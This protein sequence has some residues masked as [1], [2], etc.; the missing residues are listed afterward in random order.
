M[1][2]KVEGQRTRPPPA[3]LALGEEEMVGPH[4]TDNACHVILH[5]VDPRFLSEMESHDVASF[6][7]QAL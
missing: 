5:S 7:W 1:L 6:I 2:A 4:M 3:R